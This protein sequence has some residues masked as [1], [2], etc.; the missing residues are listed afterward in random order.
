MNILIIEDDDRIALPLKEDFERQNNSVKLAYDGALGLEHGLSGKF[1]LI[2]LD[3]MLPKLDGI[4]VCRRLRE[5][6]CAAAIIMLTARGTTADK[7]V[8][9]NCGADDYLPKPFELEEL[10]ARIQAVQRRGATAYRPNR[11]NIEGITFEQEA[12]RISY[13]GRH[14]DLTPSEYKLFALFLQ[15]PHRLFDKNELVHKLW[16]NEEVHSEQVVK[17]HIKGLRKKLE[18]AGLARDL[19]ET[20]Y[21]MGYRLKSNA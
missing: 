9:L 4:T 21:G 16:S 10:L 20:V 1:D 18:A 7:V 2:L 15:N 14:L 19:I 5:D 3:L 6:G 17:S 11:A 12:C 13:R 8:G